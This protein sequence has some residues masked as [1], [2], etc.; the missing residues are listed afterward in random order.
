MASIGNP[1]GDRH[2]P[3]STQSAVVKP[4]PVERAVIGLLRDVGRMDVT[5][6]PVAF[7]QL[8]PRR[9][10]HWLNMARLM[11]GVIENARIPKVR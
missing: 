7:E 4:D 9:Q 6:P 5:V 2:S 3:A 8:P 10:E 11:I 1:A